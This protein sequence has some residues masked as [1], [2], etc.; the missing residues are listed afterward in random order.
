MQVAARSYNELVAK[1]KT[2]LYCNITGVTF[3]MEYKETY[4]R[5]K[6]HKKALKALP[7]RPCALCSVSPQ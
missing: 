6:K 7:L 5:G 1:P 4:L 3:K 2:H